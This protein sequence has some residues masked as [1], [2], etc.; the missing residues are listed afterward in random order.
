MRTTNP[1]PDNSPEPP[2]GGHGGLLTACL[3]VVAVMLAALGLESCT[4]AGR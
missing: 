2:T 1:W 3:I 4:G